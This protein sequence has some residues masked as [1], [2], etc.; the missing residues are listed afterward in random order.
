MA[1]HF[2]KPADFLFQAGQSIDVTLLNPPETDAEGNT[3]AFS[4]ASAPFDGDLMIATRMRYTA[5]KR[6]LRKVPL[7]VEVKIEGP[8]GQYCPAETGSLSPTD[9]RCFK[10]SALYLPA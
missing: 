10:S 7:E 1:F 8:S 6:A 4:I 5:F 2:A 3:R 9:V